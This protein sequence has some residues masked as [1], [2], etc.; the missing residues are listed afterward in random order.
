PAAGYQVAYTNLPR[1]RPLLRLHD[2]AHFPLARVV[3]DHGASPGGEN[4]IREPTDTTFY[5]FPRAVTVARSVDRAI[6]LFRPDVLVHDHRS[7]GPFL[8]AERNGLPVATLVVTCCPLPGEDL[9]PFG[10]GLPPA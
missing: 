10:L 4:D 9:A 7:Y 1:F 8:A 3:P 2:I 5:A 6:K